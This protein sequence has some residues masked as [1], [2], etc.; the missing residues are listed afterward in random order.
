M[1]CKIDEYKFYFVCFLVFEN[2]ED[3]PDFIAF[4]NC[5]E[6]KRLDFGDKRLVTFIISL[7]AKLSI[8]SFELFLLLFRDIFFFFYS[9]FFFNIYQVSTDINRIIRIKITSF[10]IKSIQSHF[11]Q[12]TQ[13]EIKNSKIPSSAVLTH[14]IFYL[15]IHLKN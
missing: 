7:S 5:V 11:L 12:K 4:E 13:N 15:T 6:F 9:T 10:A 1:D 2:G 14:K 8:F 3:I